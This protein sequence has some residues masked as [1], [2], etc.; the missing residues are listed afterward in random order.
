MRIDAEEVYACQTCADVGFETRANV[1][2]ARGLHEASP[3]RSL[4]T[5]YSCTQSKLGG[6]SRAGGQRRHLRSQCTGDTASR[7]YGREVAGRGKGK[8]AWMGGWARC[9]Q[10]S[11]TTC[12]TLRS[13]STY[14]F[15][16]PRRQSALPETCPS[17]DTESGRSCPR[18]AA[19]GL[20]I[21]EGRRQRIVTVHA[22]FG[23]GRVM[24]GLHVRGLSGEAPCARI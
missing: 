13:A 21:L 4:C 1:S 24:R 23:R 2:A 9:I 15:H 19:R 11:S 7:G 5:P 12:V 14:F 17:A 6:E 16:T 20:I 18:P 22:A 3:H 8:S 10:T